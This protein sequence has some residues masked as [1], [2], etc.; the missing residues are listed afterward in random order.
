MPANL[1]ANDWKRINGC[2]L[3][4][5]RELDYKRHTRIMLHVINELVPAGSIVLNYYTPP[6]T[7][8][9]ISLPENLATE[10]HAALVGR[11]AHQSPFNYY[12]T[13]ED[14]AWKRTTDFMPVED[15]KKLDLHR[16]ALGPM[17]I[18]YQI[19]TMLASLD[20]T[21]HIITVHR[22]HEDFTE[23][24]Q[25]L[26]NALHPHLVTSH[27]NALAF[28]RS[29]E[30]V[31]HLKAVVETAP[32]AY[33]YFNADGSV[34][35]VQPKAQAWLLEFFPDETKDHGSVPRSVL[36]LLE[37]SRSRGGTPEHL[38]R[39]GK[40]EQLTAM[41]APSPLRGWILRLERQPTSPLP[42]FR[43]LPQLT[44]RENEVLKWMVEGKR[45]PE[46][47]ILLGISPR[48]VEKHV[49]SILKALGAENRACAI[50]RALEL[51]AAAGQNPRN[52][53]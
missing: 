17:G 2:L 43:P 18:N 33:G 39:S 14:A 53:T 19:A 52:A 37:Q 6:H 42:R 32:G 51:C 3:R 29:K 36:N 16:F 27:V 24:E 4:L 44:R 11:Y 15:F 38:S 35:W 30:S 34:V 21:A 41:L 23:R 47:A 9:A 45:N 1:D 40:R 46:I 22:T 7:I 20:G 12:L 28:S 48:T 26:L 25:A 49:E 8:T 13:V 31:A 50:L 10:E 5:Y